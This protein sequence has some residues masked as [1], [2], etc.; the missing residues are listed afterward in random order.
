MIHLSARLQAIADWIPP[1]A[2]VADIGSDHGRL[3]AYLAQRGDV[4]NIV[5]T[6]LRQKPLDRT[7]ALLTRCGLLDRVT[8]R[9]QDGLHGLMPQEVDTVVL[10]GM[11]GDVMASI[12]AAG[13]VYPYVT[14][15]IQ[16]ASRPETIRA[17]LPPH[18][19]VVRRE[20]LIADDGRLY[21]LIEA[22]FTGQSGTLWPESGG[23][24]HLSPALLCD[25][26]LPVY[27]ARILARLK[28]EYAA[29]SQQPAPKKD[30][31][32]YVR[33]QITALQSLLKER[34]AHP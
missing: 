2:Y 29:L 10:A 21:V 31:L 4:A 6:D 18:R 16:P 26:L 19:F 24:D 22:A 15:L 32:V 17:F 5:A 34:N 25:P 7:H 11:G 27:L 23:S 9:L 30:R 20:R 3:P 8:L 28:K 14:Y 1:G 13:P 12:L 33:G